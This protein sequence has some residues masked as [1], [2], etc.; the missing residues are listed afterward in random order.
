VKW[1]TDSGDVGQCRS[2]ATLGIFMISV[3]PHMSQESSGIGGLVSIISF[4]RSGAP[5]GCIPVKWGRIPVKW[6]TRMDTPLFLTDG[7]TR[8]TSSP[9]PPPVGFGSIV[10]PFVPLFAEAVPSSF[11]ES[12]MP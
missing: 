4:L 11:P 7:R 9:S 6:G 12:P 3:V 5:E 2:E 8:L 1:G 10:V